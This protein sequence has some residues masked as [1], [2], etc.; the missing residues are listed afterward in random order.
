MQVGRLPASMT[1]KQLEESLSST[2]G[3]VGA[4]IRPRAPLKKHRKAASADA[5]ASAQL[6]HILYE[7][8][9]VGPRDLRDTL[10]V[11]TSIFFEFHYA[12]NSLL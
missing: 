10:L 9:V 6:L 12:I 8:D 5:A 4:S 2:M 7:L 1:A 3:V 11:F